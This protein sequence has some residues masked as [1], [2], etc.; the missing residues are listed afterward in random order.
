[1]K[2]ILTK[3]LGRLVKWLRILGFDT[4]YFT[5]AN[6]GSLIIRTLRDERTIIT[7]NS[8]VSRSKGIKVVLIEAEKIKEQI[9]EV[10][11]KLNIKPEINL[12][13]SRC[14]ICNVELQDVEKDKIKDKV[15]DYV[16]NTQKDFITCPKCN[17]IYWQGTHWGNVS[18]TLEEITKE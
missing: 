17:R 3:E 12:M 11:H 2:F 7:R 4:E 14:I 16:F 8:H 15:P 9:A 6:I 13:F 1:M 5:E 10:L 18:K